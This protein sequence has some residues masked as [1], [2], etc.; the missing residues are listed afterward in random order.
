MLGFGY[1]VW[2]FGWLAGLAIALVFTVARKLITERLLGAQSLN[3]HEA[4]WERK[5]GQVSMQLVGVVAKFAS[6]QE[7]IDAHWKRCIGEDKMASKVIK[8]LGNFLWKKLPA[9]ELDSRVKDIFVDCSGQASSM[10]DLHK[11]CAKIGDR[12]LPA[13]FVQWR[14]HVVP[15]Y[16]QE[17]SAYIVQCHGSVLPFVKRL[18]TNVQEVDSGSLDEDGKT[19]DDKWP[20]QR[21]GLKNL[22]RVKG[23]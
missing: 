16:S 19:E 9:H 7:F 4:E 11:M 2:H 10:A 14:V 15:D 6:T 5:T 20:E 8:H 13:D 1:L 22:K 23:L 12:R 17:K 18:F 3:M 21:Q